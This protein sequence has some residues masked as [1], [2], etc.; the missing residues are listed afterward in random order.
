MHIDSFSFGS[1]TIDGV[2]YGSDVILLPPKVV[3]SWRRR[4][5]HRSAAED[6]AE[7]IAY[8]PETLIVGCGV[9]KRLRVPPD[10]IGSM[11]SAGIA[12]KILSTEEAVGR[13]NAQL[14]RCQKVAA[15]M[16]LT[17]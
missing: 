3:L 12:V 10:A 13:F 11:E 4:E 2:T 14:G 8:R 6:F 7:V 17:C 1:I 15:A 16:H 5:G 9:S